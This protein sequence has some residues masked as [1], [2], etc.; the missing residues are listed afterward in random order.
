MALTELN[1]DNFDEFVESETKPMLIDFWGPQ[2]VPCLG[3]MPTV[4][5]LADEYGDKIAFCKVNTAENRRLAMKLKVIGLPTFLFYKNGERVAELT[6][7]FGEDDIVEKLNSL[8]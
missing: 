8:I 2:C 7:D 5:K 1:K 6:G 3:L 4:E